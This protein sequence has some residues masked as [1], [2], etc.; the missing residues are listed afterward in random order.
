MEEAALGQLAVLH[1]V[2]LSDSVDLLVDLRFAIVTLVTSSGV[3]NPAESNLSEALGKVLGAPPGGESLESVN[4][5]H[6]SAVHHHVL[7]EHGGSVLGNLL[8]EPLL[9]GLHVGRHATDEDHVR[10]GVLGRYLELDQ[11]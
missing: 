3:P 5:G 2:T 9:G 1:L 6:A 10:S 8:G 7:G 4:L 11:I